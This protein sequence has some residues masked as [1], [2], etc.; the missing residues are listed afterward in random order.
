[1]SAG[2]MVDMYSYDEEA[3]ANVS[4]A[5]G[6]NTNSSKLLTKGRSPK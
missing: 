4:T 1:M 5:G 3:N 2:S 6:E